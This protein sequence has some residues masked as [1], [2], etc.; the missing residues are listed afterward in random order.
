MIKKIKKFF[1]RFFMTREECFEKY[2]SPDGKCYGVAGGTSSTNYLCEGCI[3]C[4]YHTM[5]GGG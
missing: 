4:K 2:K 5:I 3:G 1:G